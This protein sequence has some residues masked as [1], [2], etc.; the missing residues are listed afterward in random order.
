M[1]DGTLL[2]LPIPSGD[3][4]KVYT[5]SSLNWNGMSYY[6][7]IHSLKPRTKIKPNDYCHLDP[8]LRKGVC[9]RLL[10]WKPAFGQVDAALTHLRNND[11]STG[12][13]FL[14]FGWFRK[15]EEIDGRIVYAKGAPDLHVIYGYLQVGEIVE[16]KEDAPLWLERHPHYSYNKQ[17]NKSSNAIYLPSEELSLIPDK[18]GCDVLDYRQDR[19]LT[20]DGM[21]R[22]CWDLPDCFKK[23]H[24]T[25][26]PHPWKGDHFKSTGRGQEFVLEASPEIEDWVKGIII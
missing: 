3:D 14:F 23:V 8:D 18:K 9:D 24:I 7:I 12:D 17:W 21:S 25:Y 4:D 19:V 26:H 22:G 11:V 5:Y 2:S 20:K 15:T 6:D 16:H 1:P 13:L 10:G